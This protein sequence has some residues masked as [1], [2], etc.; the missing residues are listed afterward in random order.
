MKSSPSD[1]RLKIERL[2]AELNELRAQVCPQDKSNEVDGLLLSEYRRYG[3]QMILPEIGKEG[4]L[5][6]KAA[7]VLVIGAGGLGCPALAYLAGAGIGTIGI[8]DADE[9]DLSNCHR[10]ILHSFRDLNCKK[11]D[12]AA[13]YINSLNSNVKLRLFP[14]ALCSDNALSTIEPFDIVLDCTDNQE[15]RYL[16]SDACVISGKPLVSGSALKMDGQLAVYNLRTGPCYRCL[17]P[18][19]TPV[20]IVQTCG[21]AG[22]LGPVVGVIGVLQALETIK[23]LVSRSE[24]YLPVLTLFSAFAIPQFRTIK[25][26]S[27]KKSCI[28]CGDDT[29]ITRD[30]ITSGSYDYQQ[31][32]SPNSITN[33]LRDT[34]NISALELANMK[35]QTPSITIIDTR[36]ETQFGICH[37][38]GSSNIPLAK[39]ADIQFDKFSQPVYLVCRLGNDS[40]QAV[41]ELSNRYPELEFVNIEEGLAGWAKEDPMFPVY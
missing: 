37:I 27:K 15:T 20:E 31:F 13:K 26:R 29:R 22:I 25:L 24:D 16:I 14:Q 35:S 4:Q 18:K 8:V 2:E 28:A 5:R 10:Q 12:S 36:D 32:C 21:E 40:R 9:I 34:K 23:L 39:L 38:P 3:R 33:A 41:S 11:V 19:P 30:M 6:L 1:L 17:F 7:K